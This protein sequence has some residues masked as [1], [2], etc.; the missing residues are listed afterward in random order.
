LNEADQHCSPD[1]LPALRKIES[2]H[3]TFIV[4]SATVMTSCSVIG[5]EIGI[6]PENIRKIDA[7]DSDRLP[8]KYIVILPVVVP[9]VEKGVR[10]HET[11]ELIT[12][13]ERE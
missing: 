10:Y 2:K 12:D 6:P 1:K 11:G 5:H 3:L 9:L 7:V 13:D 4:L 8:L